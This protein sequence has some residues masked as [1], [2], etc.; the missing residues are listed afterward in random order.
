MAVSVMRSSCGARVGPPFGNVFVQY[1]GEERRHV[2]A[3]ESGVAGP[4]G[5]VGQF[6]AQG[7][8]RGGGAQGLRDEGAEAAPGLDQALALQLA[9]GLQDGVRIDGGGLHDLAG[10]GQLV[11]RFQQAQAQGLFGLLDDLDVG[12]DAAAPVDAVLDHSD[13]HPFTN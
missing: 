12:G 13:N 4:G 9:V 6:G 2:V 5:P 11:A 10:R 3:V 8:V 1:G 7:R